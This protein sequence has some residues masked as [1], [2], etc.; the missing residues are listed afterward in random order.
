MLSAP[1]ADLVRELFARRHR[2]EITDAEARW[3]LAIVLPEYG[4]T[5]LGLAKRLTGK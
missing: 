3:I 2:G 1:V 5:V 4:L